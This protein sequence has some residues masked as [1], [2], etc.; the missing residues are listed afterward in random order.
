VSSIAGQIIVLT[1]LNEED[2]QDKRYQ[3]LFNFLKNA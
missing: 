1:P 2:K 3:F